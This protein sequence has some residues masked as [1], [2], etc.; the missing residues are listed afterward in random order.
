[1]KRTV[2]IGDSHT[3]PKYGNNR[4]TWIGKCIADLKPDE[5]IHMGDLADM[6]SLCSYDKNSKKALGRSYADDIASA[7]DFNDR[8]W[9]EV[10]KSKKRLPK[11]VILEG[12]HEERITRTINTN[13]ELEGAVSFDDLQYDK[14]YDEVVRYDAGTPGIYI[15]DGI[16]YSHFFS[17]G[18]MGKAIGGE[19]LAHSLL[20]KKFISCTVGHDH[21]LD[22]CIRTRGDGSRIMGLSV[23]ASMDFP[24]DWA[25]Q[26]AEAWWN[27]IIVKDNV[28]DGTY[29]LRAISM[30]QLQEEYNK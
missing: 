15:S 17:S 19:H 4:A 6:I 23:G 5:V 8:L 30:K 1:M 27:G 24:S 11:R 14:Y 9:H 12:N 10:K 21:R 29:D 25:G 20:T 13:P 3:Q 26:G 28:E 16:A 22:Y 18:V 2:V 7:I